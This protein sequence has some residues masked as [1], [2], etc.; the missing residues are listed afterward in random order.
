MSTED[1]DMELGRLVRER[2]GAREQRASYKAQLARLAETYQ[3]IADRLRRE[4][5]SPG[6]AKEVSGSVGGPGWPKA[7]SG[8]DWEKLCRLVAGHRDQASLIRGHTRRLRQ[9]GLKPN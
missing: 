2:E 4:C 6:S 8:P 5:D 7:V 1:K 3:D 9:L